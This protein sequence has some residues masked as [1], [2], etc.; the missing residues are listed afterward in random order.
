[1]YKFES[2]ACKT[3]SFTDLT[4]LS[5]EK[6]KKREAEYGCSKGGKLRYIV[7]EKAQSSVVPIPLSQSRMAPKASGRAVFVQVNLSL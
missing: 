5:R 7:H 6:N 4:H 3:W 2:K 1:M